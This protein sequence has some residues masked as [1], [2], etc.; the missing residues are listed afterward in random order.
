MAIYK[1]FDNGHLKE[2]I[3]ELPELFGCEK[4]IQIIEDDNMIEVI[5]GDIIHYIVRKDRKM[6]YG[7]IPEGSPLKNE[8]RGYNDYCRRRVA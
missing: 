6:I 4:E 3:K 7:A 2:K 8:K 1:Y 5:C